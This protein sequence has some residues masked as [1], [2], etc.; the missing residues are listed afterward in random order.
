MPLSEV[1]LQLSCRPLQVMLSCFLT[2]TSK[3]TGQGE[4]CSQCKCILHQHMWFPKHY[5]SEQI[6][7]S[8][9]LS[10]DN[11]VGNSVIVSLAVVVYMLRHERTQELKCYISSYGQS[12][13]VHSN[14]NLNIL[15]V[16]YYCPSSMGRRKRGLQEPN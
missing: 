2:N 16:L 13:S 7:R 1:P 4:L 14:L 10:Q 9:G 3:S 6:F 8:F 5:I 11:L 15:C 12:Q